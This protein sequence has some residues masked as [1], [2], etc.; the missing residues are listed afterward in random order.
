MLGNY[1]RL[2]PIVPQYTGST[3][4]CLILRSNEV[5]E[6][7]ITGKSLSEAFILASTNPKYD[8][9]LFTE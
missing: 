6:E 5:T 8:D 4:R 9:R 1:H 2:L 3:S 7:H